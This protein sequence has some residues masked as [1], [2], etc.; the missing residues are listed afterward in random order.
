MKKKTPRAIVV[1]GSGDKAFSAGFDVNIDNPQ[2]SG[3]IEAVQEG[4][5]EPIEKLIGR[6]RGAVD[7]LASLPAPIIA[8]IN[9]DAHGGGAELAARCDLRVMEPDAAICFSEVRLGLM[10]DWGGAPALTRLVG[11]ARAADMILTA[12]KVG[13]EEALSLGLINRISAPGRALNESI[14]LAG[15]I[16]ENGPRAVR[17]ALEVIRST[18]KQSLEEALAFEAEKAVELIASGECYHGISALLSKQKPEFPD[19]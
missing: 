11:P 3:L 1:T 15:A 2:V 18:G 14:E 6:I 12:R 17:T 10:P 7:G 19:L 8:A 9:G 13:A 5:R 4:R 16:A